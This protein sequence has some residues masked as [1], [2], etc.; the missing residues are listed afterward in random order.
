[1]SDPE[2]KDPVPIDFLSHK[3]KYEETVR[4]VCIVYRKSQELRKSR[5]G[6]DMYRYSIAY[7]FLWFQYRAY[8]IR[9]RKSSN[10]YLEN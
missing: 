8:T 10:F 4:K 2:L 1:L 6:F 9:V 5:G 3:E 7:R